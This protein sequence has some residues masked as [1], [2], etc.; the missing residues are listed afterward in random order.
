[1]MDDVMD[2]RARSRRTRLSTLMVA[3]PLALAPAPALVASGASAAQSAAKPQAQQPKGVV[4]RGCLTGSK[5][6]HLDPDDAKLTIPD[7]LRVTSLRVI[8]SQVKALDGHQVEVIGTLQGIP[9]QDNGVLVADSDKARVY[10]GGGDKN[11]GEDLDTTRSEPPTI[12]A[13]TIKD[14]APDCTAAPSK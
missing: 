7:I 9:G 10:V 5:L 6:T 13:R 1:M 2:R 3:L 8:R 4:I 14:I 11:L 12:Y